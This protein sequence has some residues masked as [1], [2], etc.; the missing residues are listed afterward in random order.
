MASGIYNYVPLWKEWYIEELIGKGSYGEV[1]KIYRDV[2]GTREYAAAKYISI[3]DEMLD[4][5]INRLI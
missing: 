2:N 4:T 5:I 3:V 1:Y